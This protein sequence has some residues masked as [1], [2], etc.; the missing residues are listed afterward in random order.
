MVD[1]LV[2]Q[3]SGEDIFALVFSE[4]I[5]AT[6]MNFPDFPNFP[7]VFNLEPRSPTARRRGDLVTSIASMRTGSKAWYTGLAVTAH[8]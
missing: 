3:V 7:M 8:V 6:I 5:H 4:E 2:C 1:L